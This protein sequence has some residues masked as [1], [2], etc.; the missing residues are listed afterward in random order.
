M[1]ITCRAIENADAGQKEFLEKE[2]IE[3]DKLQKNILEI[4][5]KEKPFDVFICY[6]ETDEN[7]KRTLDSVIA[8]DIYHQL[9]QE[10]F[11][12]FY[13]AITL[14]INSDRSMSLIFLLH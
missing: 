3:I 4:V 6:K 2:A 7:G 8:N 11:K 9:T 14:R 5:H 12:V 13:A 10:G 1:L